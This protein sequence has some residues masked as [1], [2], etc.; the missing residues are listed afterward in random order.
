[1]MDIKSNNPK[2]M[3]IQYFINW[4]ISFNMIAHFLVWVLVCCC[5]LSIQDSFVCTELLFC[6]GA[7]L[8]ILPW[9][10]EGMKGQFVICKNKK[11][12]IPE[13][14]MTMTESDW[15]RNKIHKR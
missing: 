9:L 1:M 4:Q 5:F 10:R 12:R 6:Y 14:W 7:F 2:Y 13:S 11:S 8:L 15:Q 3:E